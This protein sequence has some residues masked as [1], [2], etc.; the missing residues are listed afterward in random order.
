MASFEKF[1][2]FRRRGTLRKPRRQRQRQRQCRQ[3][4]GLMSRTVAVH[5]RYKSLYISLPAFSAKQRREMTKFR[6]FLENLGHGGKYFG[7]PYEI[8]RWHY[9]FSLSRFLDIFAL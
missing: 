3:T 1:E 8:N 2:K 5:V 9:I 7:F 6:V 4:I